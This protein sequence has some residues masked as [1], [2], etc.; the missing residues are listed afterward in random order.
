MHLLLIDQSH[1]RNV[2]NAKPYVMYWSFHQLLLALGVDELL[3][4]RGGG[5]VVGICFG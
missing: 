4:I 2:F 5:V 3:V 1:Y